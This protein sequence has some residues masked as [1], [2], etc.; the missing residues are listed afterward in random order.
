MSAI[1]FVLGALVNA[2]VI[3]S[4]ARALRCGRSGHDSVS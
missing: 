2:A 3:G 4:C 1:A